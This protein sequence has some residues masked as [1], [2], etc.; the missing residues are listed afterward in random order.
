MVTSPIGGPARTPA[1]YRPIEIRDASGLSYA[2]FLRD[3]VGTNRPVVVRN[4][5]Q[6]WPALR[7]RTPPFFKERF[8]ERL[9]DVGHN[10]R[11]RFDA[12]ID[13]VL[14]STH[15]KPGPYMYRLFFHQ[16]LPE[17]LS[18]LS[19]PNPYSFPRRHASPLMPEFWRRPDGYLKLLIGGIGGRFPVMHFDTENAH[20]AITEIYGD[21]ELFS[22]RRRTL[23]ISIRTRNFPRQSDAISDRPRSGRH[24]LRT[25][26]LVACGA[27]PF[28]VGFGLLQHHR[29]IELAGLRGRGHQTGRV[30]VR[31]VRK[32]KRA[33][34]IGLGYLLTALENL[35]ERF[36]RVAKALVVPARIA[37][38]TA[39]V[40]RD[41]ATMRLRIRFAP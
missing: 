1:A 36:P 21:K 10:E 6:D 13:G 24:Y 9:I 31:L 11:M 7:K 33:Y 39:Q 22:T 17:V 2:T 32:L 35:Q 3:Y 16:H 29:A 38:A 20:A 28:A 23:P 40:A 37:P 5:T 4:A 14:A 19:P 15:D 18:D 41:P 26:P 25:L 27:R 30:R 34:F 12:F 8:G